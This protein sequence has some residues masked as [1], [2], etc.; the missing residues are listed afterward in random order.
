MGK[1]W[2]GII[3]LFCLSCFATLTA[4]AFWLEPASVSNQNYDIALPSWPASCDGLRVAALADLH[5]GSPFN[6][7]D[8]L[9]RIVDL[10]LASRPDLILLLGDYVIH[11]IP[12]GSHVELAAIAA[13][14]NSLSAPLGVFAVLGNHDHWDGSARVQKALAVAG[15]SFLEDDAQVLTWKECKFWLVGLSDFREGARRYR[16]ALAKVPLGAPALAFTHNPDV[17]PLL[18]SNLSLTIAGRTRRPSLLA[19]DRAIDGAVALWPAFRRGTYCRGR[20]SFVC[21]FRTWDQHLA[22]AFHG[23][24]GDLPSDP[25]IDSG[26]GRSAFRV[27]TARR[28]IRRR[29]T[30]R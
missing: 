17:F 11:G 28:S 1:R 8:K 5:V 14:L 15:L 25:A 10:T 24:A 20:T 3:L 4:W 12:G 23:T 27:G 26:A 7:I 2:A 29:A 13:K 22:G 21:Q 9:Q 6:G 30:L 18:P 16:E 19:D